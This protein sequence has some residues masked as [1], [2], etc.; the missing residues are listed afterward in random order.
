MDAPSSLAQMVNALIDVVNE[1]NA[2]LPKHLIVIADQNIIK[3]VPD[4]LHLDAHRGISALTNWLVRQLN[5]VICRKRVDLLEKKP[6][7]LS[8][9][10]TNIIFVR[11]LRRIG[12]FHEASRN[13]GINM[14]R[15]RFNDALNDAVTKI[16]QHMLTINGCNTFDHFAVNRKLSLRGKRDF[17]LELD[18]LIDLFDRKKIKLLPNPKNLPR[19]WNQ[20]PG[21]NHRIS[22][23]S[24]LQYPAHH[25]HASREFYDRNPHGKMQLPTPPLTRRR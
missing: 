17:W 4:V 25:H 9:L 16:D 11:M 18:N 24:Y 12:N 22:N 20:G 6:G 19:K 14:L 1:K 2:R 13:H 5:T 10:F 23:S 3:D 21:G 8:G 15:P 7:S